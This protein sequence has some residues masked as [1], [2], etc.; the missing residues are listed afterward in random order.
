MLS[1]LF[2][3]VSDNK[4]NSNSE[5]KIIKGANHVF[6]GKHPWKEKELPKELKEVVFISAT[7]IK[8][9]KISTSN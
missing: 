9:L 6:N 7:F 5:L 4:W 1:T 8:K 2:H 3:S